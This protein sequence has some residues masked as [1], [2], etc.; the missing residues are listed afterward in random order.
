MCLWILRLRCTRRRCGGPPIPF[1]QI[2]LW[3]IYRRI[4]GWEVHRIKIIPTVL[5]GIRGDNPHVYFEFLDGPFTG[6]RD[7]TFES[8]YKPGFLR[9]KPVPLPLPTRSRV[10]THLEEE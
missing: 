8:D 7:W 10:V 2:K 1:N 6:R 9:P 3:E 5:H 4:C